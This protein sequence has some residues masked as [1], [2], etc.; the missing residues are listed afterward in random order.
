MIFAQGRDAGFPHSRGQADMPLKLGQSIVFDLFPQELGGGYHHDVTRT[1]SIGY[2][3]PEVQNVYDQVMQAFDISV[4]SF[5]LG[6]PTHLMQEAVLDYYEAN[7]HPTQRSQPGTMSGYV[8]S[9]GHGLG[10]NIHERPS[11]SHVRRDDIF[12]IGNCVTIEPGLY[13]PDDGLGVRVEDTF[14]VTERGELQS[15]TSFRKDLVLPLK[16]R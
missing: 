5:G 10:L 6:K 9:L 12:Q 1:W 8:H 15:I 16:D 7:G 2:A 4:E 3:T 14:V 11:L 13:Y